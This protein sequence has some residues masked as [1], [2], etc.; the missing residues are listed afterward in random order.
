MSYGQVASEIV[1]RVEVVLEDPNG[2]DRGMD[3]L[4]RLLDHDRWATSDLLARCRDLTDAQL[5]QTFDHYIP[6]VAFWAG[7]MAGPLGGEPQVEGSLGEM[8]GENERAYAARGPSTIDSLIADHERGY[9]AFA[10]VARR[11]QAAGR[12]D[13]TFFDDSGYPFTYGGAI[14]MVILHDEG[15]RTEIVHIHARLGVPELGRVE[16]DYGLWDFARRGFG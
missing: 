9:A 12:L 4:D 2:E 15:H 11:A 16:V 3:V 13:E 5:D 7:L 14:L 10:D 1:A 6:N 8:I